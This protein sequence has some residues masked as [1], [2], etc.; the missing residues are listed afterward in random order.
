MFFVAAPDGEVQEPGDDGGGHRQEGGHARPQ[1]KQISE[2][3]SR[4]F[5]TNTVN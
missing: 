5:L 2:V 4:S 3:G 1:G